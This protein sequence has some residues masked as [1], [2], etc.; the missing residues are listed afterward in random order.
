MFLAPLA[1]VLG[2]FWFEPYGEPTILRG[3]V[4][5]FEESSGASR[6]HVEVPGR[7]TVEMRASSSVPLLEGQTVEISVRHSVWL[8]RIQ[9]ELVDPVSDERAAPE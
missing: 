9:F 5:G 1:A 6:I 4:V 2:L 7:A 8:N 3:T